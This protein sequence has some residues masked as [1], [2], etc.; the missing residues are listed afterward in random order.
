MLRGG[1]LEGTVLGAEG[2]PV[3]EAEVLASNRD[4]EMAARTDTEGHF[5]FELPPGS[6]ALSARRG[7]ETGALEHEVKLDAGQRVQGLRL[8][9]GA[10]AWVSGRVVRKGGPPVVAATVTAR[11]QGNE[12]AS[13]LGSTD[14]RGDF[15]ISS[16]TAGTY[17]FQVLM[18]EGTT[19]PQGPF[20]LAAGEHATLTLTYEEVLTGGM[21][22]HVRDEA[23][24]APSVRVRAS[25]L[26]P[27][28]SAARKWVEGLTDDKG[29]IR[30]DGLQP[31][32]YRV[33]LQ[34]GEDSPGADLLV[35]VSK[36]ATA[37]C[38]FGLGEV[39]AHGQ[40]AAVVKGRVLRSSGD[41]PDEPVMVELT[42]LERFP[43]PRRT[44]VDDQGRFQV[45]VIAGRY[46]LGTLRQHTFRCTAGLQ[47]IQLE[48]GQTLE[49]TLPLED[50]APD[51]RLRI[52]DE[53]GA[54]AASTV[55][56]VQLYAMWDLI[57]FVQTDAQ[58]RIDI[59]LPP[60]VSR[61]I[62]VPL[63][64]VLS[65]DSARTAII[66]TASGQGELTV[67]LRHLPS[68]QGRI[69]TASGAPVTRFTLDVSPVNSSARTRT[70][71]FLGIGSSF[72]I[73]RRA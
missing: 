42:R 47:Q 66:E 1:Q 43:S 38:Y 41:P 14:E 45:S 59:C 63:M 52:L 31:G 7:Q 64:T 40:L 54:P 23:N 11:R 16:L 34:R 56:Q 46:T 29:H 33:A 12:K 53:D 20:N 18:P 39:L 28:A 61:E 55:M 5:S 58:G 15:S 30:F 32:Q 26:R 70:H 65:L 62:P 37:S 8:Q 72:S 3:P 21:E 35:Q 22:C 36:N 71:A 60:P 24:P 19:F 57:E 27:R 13:S 4:L 6:Y 10:A 2:Q 68:V 50:R 49:T 44:L 9:L 51:L 69:I 48:Q 25:L 73:Y 67:R 17:D